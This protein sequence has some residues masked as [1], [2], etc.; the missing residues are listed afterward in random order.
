MS[1]GQPWL[2]ESSDYWF[3]KHVH[4]STSFALAVEATLVGGIIACVESTRPPQLYIDQ[5]AV[6]PSFRHR[7][8][9]QEL[10]RVAEERATELG[11]VRAWLS[12]DPGNPAVRV[13]PRLGYANCS[14][15]RTVGALEIRSNFKG[16][17]KD[18]ALFE[19]E[20]VRR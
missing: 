2:P 11:C 14:G 3:L 18:R 7:G 20:L 19:K 15:D 5:V 17:G 9:V 6:H 10:F 13:W 12:T 4:V 8:V 16:P 1:H